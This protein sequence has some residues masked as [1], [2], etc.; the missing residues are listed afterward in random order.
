LSVPKSLK[1]PVLFVRFLDSAKDGRRASRPLGLEGGL[2][3]L[4]LG[5]LLR[6]VESSDVDVKCLDVISGIGGTS[7][8]D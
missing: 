7:A 4:F 6:E 2:R 8:G 3:D 5:E 1:F